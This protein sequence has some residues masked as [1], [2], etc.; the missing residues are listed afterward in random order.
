MTNRVISVTASFV[1]AVAI[2]ALVSGCSTE[3]PAQAGIEPQTLTLLHIDGGPELDPALGWFVDAVSD[4]SDGAITVEVMHSCCGTE[5]DLEESLVAA[6]AAGEADMGWVGT[7]V[8]RE[9][10]VDALAALTAPLLVGGYALEQRVLQSTEAENALAALSELDVTPLA[11][12]PG[13]IRYPLATDAPIVSLEDWSGLTIASFHSAQNADSFTALGARPVDVTFEQRDSGIYEG[14]IGALENSLVMQDSGREQTLPYATVDVGLW[15]R[16][17]ALIAYP[18]SDAASAAI[19]EILQSAAADVVAMTRDLGDLDAE[20]MT[21]ACADGARFA[22]A[23]AASLSAMQAA[24]KPELDAIGENADAAP[25]L[26]AILSLASD[27]GTEVP[28]IPEGCD[29]VAPAAEAPV[30]ADDP[31]VVNG[32]FQ[33]A[34]YT[35]QQLMDA[36]FA[37]QDAKNAAGRFTLVF[38]D[39]DFELIASQGGSTFGCDGE[40]TVERDQLTVEYFPGGDCGPGGVFF[41]ATFVVDDEALT[42][43]TIDA[44]IEGDE[45]LFG[46]AP[47]ARAG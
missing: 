29:G 38:Q 11:L 21:E 41:T 12:L 17:S 23:G 6:V 10:G 8:F 32:R 35:Q 20:A 28:D 39:G 24:V 9:L 46:S 25:L 26:D 3:R 44:P 15:P 36:G 2:G 13:S 18:E 34:D 42:F 40:Y 31:A 14:T 22:L 47:L 19:A 27:H 43:T 4:R 33:S 1:A 45:Y 7:R 37:A 16:S 5:V 30:S